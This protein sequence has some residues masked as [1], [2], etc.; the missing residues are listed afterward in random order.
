MNQVIHVGTIGAVGSEPARI[1]AVN[2]MTNT[3][4]VNGYMSGAFTGG[5]V[6]AHA[7]GAPVA[8]GPANHRNDFGGTS[9]A[10]PLTAGVAALVL[11][12]EP[13]LTWVEARQ[14]MRDTAISSTSPTPTRSARARRQRHAVE[15]TGQ[16]P[17]RSNW[18]G[19]GRI[20][21]DGA[22]QN[23]L[24][25]CFTCDIVVRDNLADTGAV[26][27]GGAFWNSPDIWVRNQ[28][29]AMEGAA[30]LPANYGAAGPH[31]TRFPARPTGSTRV[32]A[33]TGPARRS[34]ATYAS[35]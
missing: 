35:R 27:S 13:D 18:Y 8:Q 3:I 16:P 28:S 20:N 2:A 19:Y 9:S 33:T 30:A 4:T 11:S 5:S 17:V 15:R 14:I 26:P 22:V 25:L 31:M 23:A 12:A 34:T 21:A 10:T 24:V 29:P 1:T 32:C 6:N 7:A